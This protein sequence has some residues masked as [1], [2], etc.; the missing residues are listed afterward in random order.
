M[1]PANSGGSFLTTYFALFYLYCVQTG[2]Q[3]VL[4]RKNIRK[5]KKELLEQRRWRATS[6]SISS[7]GIEGQHSEKLALCFLRQEHGIGSL[8][9]VVREGPVVAY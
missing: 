3:V 8:L 9:I 5:R 2:F 7:A 1:E 4:T 6:T